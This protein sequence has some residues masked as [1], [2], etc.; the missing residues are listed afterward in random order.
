M[1]I[2]FTRFRVYSECPWKYKLMFVDGK[3]VPLTPASSLGLSLHRALE[4]F[5]RSRVNEL[6]K[7]LDCY[8][9]RWIGGGYADEQVKKEHFDKG[10]KILEKYFKQEQERR[11][12]IEGIERE[13]IYPLGRHT[14]RGMIDRMDK[15]PDGGLE[16]ID[17]KTSL[18]FDEKSPVDRTLQLRFYALGVRESLG[19]KP[20]WLT[21][22]YL[23]AGKREREPYDDSR[24][25]ELKA[26]I[27][28]AADRIENGDFKPD[29][30]FC[31]SCDFR[32]TCTHSTARS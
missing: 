1:E 25:D 29:T 14:V 20:S 8:E 13:F 5:H 3:K 10:I 22:H 24:E 32:R 11:T 17:Y 19:V 12:Q 31:P 26:A 6:D 16:I 2:S 18:D 15:H 30:A 7:L 21:I 23:A 9:E 4:S 28:R 27:E